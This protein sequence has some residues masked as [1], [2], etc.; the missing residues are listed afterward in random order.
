M[1]R[2]PTCP[3]PTALLS[4]PAPPDCRSGSGLRGERDQSP[5]KPHEQGRPGCACPQPLS[6]R[7]WP[8]PPTLSPPAPS[9]EPCW[10]QTPHL[11]PL[12]SLLLPSGWSPSLSLDFQPCSLLLKASPGPLL[13]ALCTVPI[14]EDTFVPG[15]G[16]FH[17]ESPRPASPPI[18]SIQ[19][20]VDSHKLG[21]RLRAK[22][23][24]RDVP[25][26]HQP[27]GV[28]PQTG[29]AV[30]C[31]LPSCWGKTFKSQQNY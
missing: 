21:H 9:Q 2:K 7:A 31:P 28:S 13:P 25:T 22:P 11:P 24:A 27:A 6:L 14:P 20:E 16:F 1:I 12:T 19:K 3:P 30:P 10:L 4:G 17:L 26:P 29:R 8:L 5:Y 15:L 18:L 23:R